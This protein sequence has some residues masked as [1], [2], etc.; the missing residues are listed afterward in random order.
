MS[1]GSDEQ[2]IS[3]SCPVWPSPH[4]TFSR[5]VVTFNSQVTAGP[6]ETFAEQSVHARS[7]TWL[8]HSVLVTNQWY[9]TGCWS[10]PAMAAAELY[11]W[12][13]VGHQTFRLSCYKRTL[14]FGINMKEKGP[15]EVDFWGHRTICQRDTIHII[16]RWFAYKNF[17][18]QRNWQ[19]KLKVFAAD[20]IA[21]WINCWSRSALL[22][23]LLMKKSTAT[24][25]LRRGFVWVL[26][27]LMHT[28]N[29]DIWWCIYFQCASALNYK[30]QS[31]VGSLRSARCFKMSDKM[32]RPF[33][34]T[35]TA[36]NSVGFCPVLRRVAP[37]IWI[38]RTTNTS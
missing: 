14:E 18:R 38:S 7:L 4:P 13:N 25:L 16:I 8:W 34:S 36:G 33:H 3:D 5:F 1:S 15:H 6:T 10:C 31:N 20:S 32:C 21:S 17:W 27:K 19:K 23:S 28:S 11:G 9:R 26:E 2:R 29:A 37:K 22:G 30:R 12:S 24:F 35:S